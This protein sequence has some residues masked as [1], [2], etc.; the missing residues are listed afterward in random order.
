MINPEAVTGGPA[1][2]H[3]VEVIERIE[4]SWARFGTAGDPTGAAFAVV[5]AA[6]GEPV[7]MCGVDH[8]LNTGDA[9]FGYW[10]AAGA[11]GRGFATRAVTL[12]TGWLFLSS[13][14]LAC[15]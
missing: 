10:L 2:W 3:S 7:G 12:M 15:S 4:Q 8:W 11:R 14:P 5:D 13:E 6:L 9:Q 1:S